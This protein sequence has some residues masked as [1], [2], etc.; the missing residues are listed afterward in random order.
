MSRS[1]EL[2][3]TGAT[4]AQAA[5][6]TTAARPAQHLL[7]K[8]PEVSVFFWVIKILTTG[9]GET[10][11]D[12]LGKLPIV[13]A[14]LSVLACIGVFVGA[15]TLQFRN[16]RYVP[17]VYWLCVVMISIFGTM[18]ADVV[19]VGLK[20]PY[21]ASTALYVIALAVIFV[22]WYRSEGTLSIHSIH[23]RRRET[24]YWLTVCATFA[25]GT[26]TGDMTATTLHLGYLPSALMFLVLIVIPALAHA[27]YRRTGIGLAAVPAFWASYVLTRP[28]GASFADWMGVSTHRKGLGWGTGPVSGVLLVVIVGLV[29]YLTLTH[30]DVEP[31]DLEPVA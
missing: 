27:N 5:G 25:L 16:D 28:L 19:H 3:V 17:W 24:F 7:S 26:A 29:G 2:P 10:T 31:A 18:A 15:M 8:V 12:F 11:S 13:F 21:E 14:V 23:T 9:M 4:A 1:E 22:A 30:R 20:L 6:P